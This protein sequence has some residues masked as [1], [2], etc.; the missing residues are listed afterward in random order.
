MR[1][2]SEGRTQSL[3]GEVATDIDDPGVV[4]APDVIFEPPFPPLMPLLPAIR[5]SLDPGQWE[6]PSL[7][8]VIKSFTSSPTS[9]S[10]GSF[11]ILQAR[12]ARPPHTLASHHRSLKPQ[13]PTP[14][15]VSHSITSHVLGLFTVQCIASL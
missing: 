3:T 6:A 8:V 1:Q 12:P 5:D 14:R 11:A 13:P 4:M 9:L 2:A 10:S 7:Q 15:C